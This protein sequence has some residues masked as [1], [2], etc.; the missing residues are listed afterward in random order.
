MEL[1]GRVHGEELVHAHFDG[2]GTKTE[3][4]IAQS[5]L[6]SSSFTFFATYM[7]GHRNRV[8]RL[9]LSASGANAQ[10]TS[11]SEGAD[12]FNINRK[13]NNRFRRKTSP[14]R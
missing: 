3:R 14:G 11:C 13:L 1:L 10:T 9:L 2:Y 6:A 12:V 4:Q 7:F 5:P 8:D